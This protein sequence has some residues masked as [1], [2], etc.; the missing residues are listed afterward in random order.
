VEV[1]ALSIYSTD[2]LPTPACAVLLVSARTE[3]HESLQGIFRDSRWRLQGAWTARDGRMTIRRNHREIPVVICEESLP[4]GDWK[5]LLE[6]LD[7]VSVRPSLI[8][9]SRLADERLWAEVLN[10]GAFDLLLGA[11]FE[12]EEVLRVT[13]SAW[14]ARHRAT[15]PV[16]RRKGPGIALGAGFHIEQA[17]A[18]G[19]Q[20]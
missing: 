18:S 12:P 6:E 10:L 11:P 7:K 8:V 2:S 16:V 4:D 13:E 15:G 19:T 1:G 14:W 5:L 20:T 3:D 9:S 17:L